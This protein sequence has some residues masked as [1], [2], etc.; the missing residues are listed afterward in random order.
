[1]IDQPLVLP[2][3]VTLANRLCKSAMTEGLATP[4]GR[5]WAASLGHRGKDFGR[6]MTRKFA[7]HG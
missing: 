3:G 6:A 2:C 4:Q 5:A 1:M 7:W